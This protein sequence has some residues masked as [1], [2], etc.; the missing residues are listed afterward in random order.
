LA[1]WERP[2]GDG[3]QTPPIRL[4][5]FVLEPRRRLAT[6]RG[7][8]AELTGREAELLAFLMRNPDSYFSA[9]ELLRLA[10]HS[11]SLSAD[12][13][14]IYVGRLRRKLAPLNPPWTLVGQQWL[15]YELRLEQSGL[16]GRVSRTSRDL[17]LIAYRRLD[18]LLRRRP[19][20]R[21]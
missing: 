15:G 19:G 4:R 21:I 11:E 5:G 16:L 1:A 10:W 18:S 20:A 6:F 17:A 2:E 8:S 9:E 12:E 13:L 3:S 14:R 7:K